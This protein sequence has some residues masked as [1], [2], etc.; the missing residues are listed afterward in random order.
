M[1]ECSDP[2]YWMELNHIELSSSESEADTNS[3]P[4]RARLLE[5][6]EGEYISNRAIASWLMERV[7]RRMGNAKKSAGQ[8]TY[9]EMYEALS[10]SVIQMTNGTELP[11][12]ERVREIVMAHTFQSQLRCKFTFC[13]FKCGANA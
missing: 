11:P 6:L 4:V 12:F 9:S 2:E 8:E 7:D 1:E 10:T 3:K 13:K 5:V